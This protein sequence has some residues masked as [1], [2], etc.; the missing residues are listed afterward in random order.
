MSARGH[1]LR[2]VGRWLALPFY[3]AAGAV[4]GL[5][6]IVVVILIEI[7]KCRSERR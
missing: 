2:T 3:L 7:L 6:L 4:I 5:T 1:S